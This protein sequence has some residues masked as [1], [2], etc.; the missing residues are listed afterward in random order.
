MNTTRAAQFDTVIVRLAP[1]ASGQTYL[2]TV[3][4]TAGPTVDALRRAYTSPVTAINA[5][6]GM[7]ALFVAGYTVAAVVD[8]A[9]QHATQPAADYELTA[10]EKAA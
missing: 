6:R 3:D 5:Y 1:T 2:L 4:S 8:F 7:C 10:C 9:Q